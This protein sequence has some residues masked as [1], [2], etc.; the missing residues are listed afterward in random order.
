MLRSLLW[1]VVLLLAGAVEPALERCRA[2]GGQ[3]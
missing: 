2:F 3:G 1:V